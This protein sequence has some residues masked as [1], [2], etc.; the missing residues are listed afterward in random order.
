MTAPKPRHLPDVIDAMLAL[1]PESEKDFRARLT[2]VKADC[3]WT[4]PEAMWKRWDAAQWA[5]RDALFPPREPQPKWLDEVVALYT[6]R[7]VKP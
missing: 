4:A 6:G 1:I 7:P 3:N 2:S 5:V